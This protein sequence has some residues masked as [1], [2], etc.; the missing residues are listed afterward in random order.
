MSPTL[1]RSAPALRAGLRAAAAR[2]AAA[3]FGTTFV[4]GKATLPDLPC[5]TR[6][7]ELP[8]DQ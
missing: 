1:L 3:A 4:R 6:P 8:V 7:V 5:K 2:P